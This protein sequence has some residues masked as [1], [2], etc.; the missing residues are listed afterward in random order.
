MSERVT[1]KRCLLAD[2]IT[3]TE[4]E[5]LRMAFLANTVTSFDANP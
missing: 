4:R 5:L 3:R 1:P 2:V